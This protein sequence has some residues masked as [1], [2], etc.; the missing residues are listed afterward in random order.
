MKGTATVVKHT[1]SHYLLTELPGWNLF[2]AVLRGKV[3][4]KGS[5]A[6]NPVAV[7]DLV[8]YELDEAGE[9]DSMAAIT[10]IHPRRNY[11]IRKSTNLSRQN[12][13]IA[14]NVDQAV[15]I[16]SL[17]FPEIKLPFLDRILVTCEV[18]NVPAIIVLNKV[19][20]YRDAAKE[21]VDAF[22]AIYESAG[23]RVIETSTKTGEGIDE[24][25]AICRDK[26]TLFSGES[27]VGKSSMIKAIDP[28]LEPRTGEISDV[29]LQGKHT[30][31]FYEM[32]RFSVPDGG[33]GYIVDTPGIRGFGLVDL[34]KEEIALYFPE[35][36][37]ASEDCRF[38][39]CT[40][41]HEPGCA[42]KRAVEE[43]TITPE[44]YSSYLGM[45]EDE[46]KYR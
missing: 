41:T 6:T 4:L 17:M 5:T 32:Y 44:R 22:K 31:T 28:S 21:E 23:Y 11:V 39:P 2:P 18:Y 8:D 1:G 13:I 24:L 45:L 15:I 46:G 33:T 20:M 30:T 10:S 35:M 43:G 12:H 40:H 37:R 36:L 29:H 26:V 27:G 9:G 25:R 42:V 38:S 14:A 3:R 16:T 7:G 19:D 34:K